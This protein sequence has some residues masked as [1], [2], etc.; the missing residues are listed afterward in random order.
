L[1]LTRAKFDEL[2]AGVVE[3]TIEPTRRALIDACCAP[4]ELDKVILVCGSTRITA[5]QEAIKRETRKGPYTG[6]NPA[7]VVALAAA[8]QGGVLTG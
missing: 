4:R 5:V 3:R 7:E 2:S 6:V 8:V 1:T